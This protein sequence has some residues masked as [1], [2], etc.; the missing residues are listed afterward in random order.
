MSIVPPQVSKAGL[1]LGSDSSGIDF[2]VELS[3][4]TRGAKRVVY[5]NSV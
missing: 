5:S 1:H 3:D 4:P 2:D